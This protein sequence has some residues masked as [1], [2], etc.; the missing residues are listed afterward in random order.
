[1]RFRFSIKCSI[2]LWGLKNFG[3]IEKCF[4]FFSSWIPLKIPSTSVEGKMKIT[5]HDYS[6][7]EVEAGDVIKEDLRNQTKCSNNDREEILF[8]FIS[9]SS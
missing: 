4:T 1:M 6:L 3:P 7:P 9:G 2:L 5:I 8:I